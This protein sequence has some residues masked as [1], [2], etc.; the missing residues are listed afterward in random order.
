MTIPPIHIVLLFAFFSFAQDVF[1]EKHTNTPSFSNFREELPHDIVHDIF[2]DSRGFIWFATKDGLCR[3]DGSVFIVYSELLNQPS[4]SSG[5]ILCISEDSK[6]NIWAGTER[7]LNRINPITNE[8]RSFLTETHPLLKDNHIN[9][10]YFCPTKKW[11]WIATRLGISW[12]DTDEEQFVTLNDEN[13]AFNYETKVIGR[14]SDHEIYVGTH[15][16][17]HIFD[18]KGKYL[19]TITWENKRSDYIVFSAHK[20][21]EGQVWV[22]TN[23]HMLCKIESDTIIPVA[24]HPDTFNEAFQLVDLIESDSILWLI[25]RR[26][27]ILCYD[28]HKQQLIR[29][30][31]SYSL[32]PS[33]DSTNKSLRL[34]CG[35]KDSQGTIWVGTYYLGAFYHSK[36]FNQFLHIPVINKSHSP[37]E[38]FGNMVLDNK[39]C[40]WLGS[41][42]HQIIYFNPNDHSMQFYN[43]R[44]EKKPIVACNPLFIKDDQLWV[45]TDGDGLM[46]FDMAKKQV[47]NRYGDAR[48]DK[49]ASRRV[50]TAI[51][52]SLGRIWVGL[53]GVLAGGICKFDD[54]TNTF[55]TYNPPNNTLPVKDVYSIFEMNKN[56]LWLGTRN[57]GLFHYD[58]KKNTFTPIPLLNR[59]NLSVSYIF[60]DSKQRIWIGTFGQGLLCLDQS[61][62]VKQVFNHADGGINNNICG[63][64]EDVEGRVWISSF[65]EIAYYD[66]E[67]RVFVKYDSHSNFPIQHVMSMSCL[68]Y[69]GKPL[70]Y[71]GGQNGLVEINF[72]ELV[73]K[74]KKSPKIVLTNFLINNKPVDASSRSQVIEEQKIVLRYN[75]NNLTFLYALLDFIHPEK[76]QSYYFL[77]GIDDDWHVAGAQRQATYNSLPSGEYTFKVKSYRD[78]YWSD[79]TA[80]V[81]ITLKPAPWLSWWAYTLYILFVIS[82]IIVFFYYQRAKI[83]LEHRLDLKNVELQHRDKMHKFRIDLFTNFSHE[84]R[85]PLTLI[86]EPLNDLLEQN[87][88]TDKKVK[89]NLSGIRLN[90]NK[91]MELVNQ[92]MDYRKHEEKKMELN[93]TEGAIF[94]FIQNILSTFHELSVIQ[95]HSISLTITD[96]DLNCWYNP[97]LLEKVF[98][99]VLMNAFKYSKENSPII[100]ESQIVSAEAVASHIKTN[101]DFKEALVISIFNEGDTLPEDQLGKIF[102]PFYRLKRTHS[103]HS[104][105]IGLSLNKMI[106]QLHHGDIWAENTED[107]GVTFNILIPIGCDHLDKE[108]LAAANQKISED[109]TKTPVVKKEPVS[110]K[111]PSILLV[112][113]NNEIR[114]Y[115]KSKLSS[116]YTIY[117][118]DNGNDAIRVLKS[119]DISLIISDIM[120]SGMSGIELCRI[121]KK[122]VAINHI[123]IILLTANE[124][125]EYIREGFEAGANDYITKPFRFDI[126]LA[127]IKGQ[128]NNYERLRN[129]FQQQV[130]PEELN[131]EVT[132][133]D[134]QFLQKCYDLL[135]EN[136]S[137]PDF[138][139]EKLGKEIGLSR[140]HLYRKI[141]YLTNMSPSRFVLNIRLKVAADL[142]KTEGVSVSDVCYKVG[143]NNLSYFTKCFKEQFGELP[144]NYHKAKQ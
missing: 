81:S 70:L 80:L 92:L 129:M 73:R 112:E 116:Y 94:P 38:I 58:I 69:P 119:K 82:L 95:N 25:S 18:T 130:N 126:L 5:R 51:Q 30:G 41:Q 109:Y 133:Y 110:E 65:Y 91:I 63:I 22:G 90:V 45:A 49:L 128:L 11:I 104:S 71:F 89:D 135:K 123:P 132:D 74:E 144:S 17:M 59:E 24:T 105:G 142:L 40:I 52:D 67:A 66:E 13:P 106:M 137:N 85:T 131:V 75:Q 19:R 117:D 14:Y 32:Y 43:L 115:L 34:N 4:M 76:N 33:G 60:R 68:S 134:Q 37:V 7:G 122:D 143:F 54:K 15:R 114:N 79:E 84:I 26:M 2:E 97:Q 101:R 113:D 31:H 141:K 103:E 3:Y 46:T 1:S 87:L 47:T 62:E 61:T 93:A 121:I 136:L 108:E 99:N 56:E 107:K 120:M 42:N 118:C 10:L 44:Q 8:I 35:L 9:K 124:S 36:H 50:N 127:R 27:G 28:K 139:I 88:F 98:Y 102:E 23:T 21:A 111:K 16:G 86:S 125:D 100:M 55:I 77:E 138:S 29:F 72:T 6:G 64:M 20:D 53:N 57:N 48:T 83:K 78:G 39:G 96:K 140:V 12:Y